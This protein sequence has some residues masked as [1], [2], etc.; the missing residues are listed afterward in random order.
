MDRTIVCGELYR[1]FK[2]MLYQVIGVA[3]HS[4]TME[5]MVVYQALYG[6]YSLYVRPLS[7][8]LSEVDHEKY[9]EVTAKYRFTRIE[10]KSL[11]ASKPEYVQTNHSLS[12]EAT[13]RNKPKEDNVIKD[14]VIKDDVINDD[15][16]QEKEISEVKTLTNLE[17]KDSSYDEVQES[18]P[19]ANLVNENLMAFLDAKDYGEKLEVLYS[20]RKQIDDR[21]MSDIEMSLDLPIG[22]GTLEERLFIVRD[23]LQTMEKYE[24]R[25]L[26]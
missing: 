3:K 5:P 24:G 13:Q 7:M 18:H 4:E 14:N 9:P 20:I 8:F 22:K 26:R 2:G 17:T 10:R 25:R 23:N 12:I 19:E 1:H 11:D 21:L 15:L 6:D 16:I